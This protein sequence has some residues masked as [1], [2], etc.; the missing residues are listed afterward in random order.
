MLRVHNFTVWLSSSEL[1]TKKR[2]IH[3][4]SGNSIPSLINHHHRP[5]NN[6]SSHS[7]IPPSPLLRSS[8]IFSIISPPSLPH[9]SSFP[10]LIPCLLSFIAS[11]PLLHSSSPSFL[12]HLLSLIPPLSPVP[13][14]QLVHLLIFLRHST[15]SSSFSSLLTLHPSFTHSVSL[16]EVFLL[17]PHLP[18]I[19][20]APLP[21]GS[22]ISLTPTGSHF[23]S[24]PYL[25]T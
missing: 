19:P 7:L 3:Q 2:T 15:S 22:L 4:A 10:S 24:L 12:L 8:F 16:V 25:L 1:N 5:C 18:P 14:L 23:P 13:F 9:S 21:F 20:S 11:F 6:P 17:L